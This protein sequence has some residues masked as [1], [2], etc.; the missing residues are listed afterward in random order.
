MKKYIIFFISLLGLG[1]NK[2]L[3]ITPTGQIVVETTED[4]YNLVSYPGRGYPINNFQYLVDDQWIKESYVIGVTKNMDIIN[5]TFDT[6]V[7]RVNYLSASTL[8]NRTYTYINRWNMVVSLVDESTGDE[9]IKKIAKAEAK[10]LR[11]YDHFILVN[12]FAKIYTPATAA[13]DGGICIMDK[14]DLEAKPVKSTVAE[15]YDFIEKD[16]DEAIPYLQATPKDVY[17]PSLAFAWA[18]KAKVLLFKRDYENAKAA[19]LQALT[20]NNSLFDMVSYTNQG[21]PTV[22]AMPAGSNPETL[23]YMYMSSYNE[24]NY[25]YSYCISGELKTLFGNH[26]ARYNLF[27]DSTNKSYLDIGAHTA[28]WKTKYTAF[29]YPTVGIQVPEVYLTLAEC[30]ARTGD[31]SSAMDIVNNLR[32]KR[33][34][35]ATAAKLENPGTMVDVVKLIINERRKE[36]LFGFNRFWDLKRYNTE[37]E[38]AK[39]VTHTFPLVNTAVAQQT[40]VLPPDSR[41]YVIPF[42]QDVLKKNTNLTINTNETLPW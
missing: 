13:T 10:V 15:V 4:F 38:F 42:A 9:S 11:A 32:S 7:S 22:L 40:Y 33:I 36:L 31:L 25:A 35:D 17:H 41:L 8:Y 14:Y 27:F 30:Y 2:Y 23:S 1:C 18:F 5:F 34:T 12:T 24:L 20:Y 39:T 16:L 6:S 3:D 37:T 26:D 29:F 19:A 28:Y 21:G